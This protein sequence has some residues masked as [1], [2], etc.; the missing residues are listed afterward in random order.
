MIVLRLNGILLVFFRNLR[1]EIALLGEL[2]SN[3]LWADLKLFLVAGDFTLDN[4]FD[5]EHQLSCF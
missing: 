3:V 4:H 2:A 1:F 5:H